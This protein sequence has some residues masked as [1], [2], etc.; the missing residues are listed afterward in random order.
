M[1]ATP[2]HP[3]AR[4]SRRD[5]GFTLIELLVVLAILALLAG[6]AGPRVMSYLGGAKTQSAGIQM[7]NIT[8]A[9]DLFLLDMGRYPSAEEGVNVLVAPPATDAEKWNGP[10]L[11]RKD[12]II[13]PWGVPYRYRNPGR[14]APFEV[15][16]LGADKAEGGEGED[17]DVYVG[18]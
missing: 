1:L 18:S 11:S 14:D 6:F 4:P 13:D 3:A 7:Q 5:A 16:S 8:A 15:Y 17:A 10:Y 2:D 12:A 9:M